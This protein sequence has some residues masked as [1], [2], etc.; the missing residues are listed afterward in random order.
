MCLPKNRTR[1][2]KVKIALK[3]TFLTSVFA[4]T[5]TSTIYYPIPN[6][7][8]IH[9]RVSASHVILAFMFILLSM[10]SSPESEF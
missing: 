3:L 1:Q 6:L 9:L 8:G 4:L 5:S 10:F 2:G 7:N